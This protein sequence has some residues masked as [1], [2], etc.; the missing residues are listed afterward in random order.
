[1]GDDITIR[2]GAARSHDWTR[3]PAKW[4][5]AGFLAGAALI[6]LVWVL[7]AREPAPLIQRSPAIVTIPPEAAGP[8]SVIP[9][10]PPAEATAERQ[11]APSAPPETTIYPSR[12]A[13]LAQIPRDPAPEEPS[14]AIADA[15]DLYSLLPE[16]EP[17]PKP[18]PASTD[19]G[20]ASDPEPAPTP[21][22]PFAVRI[23]VNAATPAELELLPGVGPVIAGRIADNR[24]ANGPF[25]NL[26]DLQRVKGI[27]PKTAER[28]APHVRF[29]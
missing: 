11:T 3:G 4:A 18:E 1:M 5:S 6:G 10:P 7:T 16:P 25:R 28:L 27:G 29:D 9:P 15:D 26:R 20:L 12:V 23:R 17:E 8:A 24:A 21:E 2:S 13:M 14:P 22:A 19:P